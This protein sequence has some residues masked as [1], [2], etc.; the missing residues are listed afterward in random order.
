MN[1][2]KGLICFIS[3][4]LLLPMTAAA[5]PSLYMNGMQYHV[6]PYANKLEVLPERGVEAR[7][8]RTQPTPITHLNYF[9]RGSFE[10]SYEYTYYPNVAG[11]I[12]TGSIGFTLGVGL[13]YRLLR[14]SQWG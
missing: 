5:Q 14:Q 10:G 7:Y 4:C 9:W 2:R 6:N 1:Y 8:T 12:H 3:L 13:S 11:S